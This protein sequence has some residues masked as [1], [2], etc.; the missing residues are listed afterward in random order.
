MLTCGTGACARSTPECVGGQPRTCVPGTPGS[1][2]CNDVD[3]DCDGAIDDGVTQTCTTAC[4]TGTQTCSAG[5][6]GPCSRVPMAE[7]C[8]GLD[9]DCDGTIDDIPD[10][11]RT[12]PGFGTLGPVACAGPD[13][14]DWSMRH[15]CCQLGFGDGCGFSSCYPGY[16][17]VECGACCER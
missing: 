2:S 13:G 17:L 7:R 15:G 12:C 3:D 6:F 4:G 5:S 9:D 16:R 1:E 11:D 10:A 14:V 8:N